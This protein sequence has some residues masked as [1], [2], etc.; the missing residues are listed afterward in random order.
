MHVIRK[1][2]CRE[3]WVICWN[4]IS[5]IL[6]VNQDSNGWLWRRLPP[7]KP[8]NWKSKD[9]ARH[10][11]TFLP[12]SFSWM[13]YQP[14]ERI[15]PWIRTKDHL[16]LHTSCCFL[17]LY[18]EPLHNGTN[19]M[20]LTALSITLPRVSSSGRFWGLYMP[21]SLPPPPTKKIGIHQ[22]RRW[23]ILFQYM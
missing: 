19:G 11:N 7:H 15:L 4:D 1:A 6:V 8:F 2:N 17:Q 5:I 23:L 3:P 22:N 18:N 14:N 9:P 16:V 21:L 20:T 13:S 10:M 12:W